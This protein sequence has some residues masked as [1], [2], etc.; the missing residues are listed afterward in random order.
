MEPLKL[1]AQSP[2][3]NAHA[4]RFVRTIKESCLDKMILFGESSLREAIS[5]FTEH[6]HQERNHQGLDNKIIRHRRSIAKKYDGT[7]NRGEGRPS[8]ACD[9]KELIV[10]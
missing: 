5:Q 2:N 6:Y 1:P 7:K 10:Y 8:A 9:L 4:E 3:L